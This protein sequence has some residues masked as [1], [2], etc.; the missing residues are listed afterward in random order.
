MPPPP[1]GGPPPQSSRPAVSCVQNQCTTWSCGSS[2]DGQAQVSSGAPR[3][4]HDGSVARIVAEQGPR[5]SRV[6]QSAWGDVDNCSTLQLSGAIQ[7]APEKC[8]A[9]PGNKT[10]VKHTDPGGEQA[11]SQTR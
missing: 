1:W 8:L 10:L 3:I 9:P 11:L 7:H 4:L 5:S 2:A 6:G